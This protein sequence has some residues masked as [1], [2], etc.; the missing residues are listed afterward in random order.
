MNSKVFINYLYNLSYEILSLVLPI[1]TVP[2]VSR[3]LGAYQLGNYYYVT[4]VVTYY[5][6]IAALGTVDFGQREIAKRQDNKLERSNKFWQILLFRLFFIFLAFI[7]YVPLMLF[8]AVKYRSLYV[9]DIITFVSWA[10]DVS[11]YFQGMENY[12][13][14]ALKNGLVKI[15]STILI[16]IL[17]KKQNDVWIYTAIYALAALLGNLTMLPYLRDS[18]EFVKVSLKKSLAQFH[19]IVS[20]FLPVVAIQLYNSLDKIILGKFSSSV[21]VGYFSQVQIIVN[22]C[23]IFEAAYGG[24]M[25][26]HISYLYHKH[27]YKKI[28]EYI[29]SAIRYVYMIAVPLVLGCLCIGDIFVPTFFGP[30]YKGAIV[31][32]YILSGLI[33]VMG[34]GQLQ[35]Q[36][37]V[38]I[39]RQKYFSIA[40]ISAFLINFPVAVILVSFFHLGASGAAVATV[41][42]EVAATAIEAY[43]L[44]DLS[45]LRPYLK[46]LIHYVV[47]GLPIV[48]SVIV[49]RLLFSAHLIIVVLSV[50]LGA[51]TYG[52]ALLLCKDSMFLTVIKPITNKIGRK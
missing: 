38:A 31:T 20:L 23:V 7:A 15:L 34:M 52:I 5:G 25:T 13:V 12:K 3:V 41:L 47:L 50:L 27:D 29:Q 40:T 42:S 26:P 35:G 43:Y 16:F 28:K 32:L 9:I 39:N 4:A 14:T 10:V 36:F 21:Q 30:K 24:V 6:I 2:Y 11:W 46:F 51:I 37:L 8:S 18:I 48:I 22:F 49:V 44:K 45:G 33:I 17:V 19:S 1:F